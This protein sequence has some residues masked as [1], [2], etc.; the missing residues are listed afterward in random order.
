M[1][2]E[3]SRK[4]KNARGKKETGHSE[5]EKLAVKKKQVTAKEKML[6]G[7]ENGS[8]KKKK[9]RDCQQYLLVKISKVRM[10]SIQKID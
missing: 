4:K 1:L 9:D 8:Q 5:R 7:K 6:A 2:A 10:L 3:R